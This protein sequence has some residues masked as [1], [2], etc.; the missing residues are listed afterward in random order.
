MY[1]LT[2]DQFR[3]HAQKG[4]LIPVYKEI[5]ADMETP[6]SA[7]HKIACTNSFLLES[8]EGGEN[9]AR[10]SFI[11]HGD[12]VDLDIL[13]QF[14]PVIFSELPRFHGGVVGYFSYD[15]IRQIENIP[16]TNPDELNLPE[17]R[18]IFAK[19]L[20]AFDHVKHKI[21]I[22]SNAFINGSVDDAYKNACS[23][24][25]ILEKKLLEEIKPTTISIN[26]TT[27]PDFKSN[28]TKEEY[29]T[30][31]EKA[32]EYIKAGDIFQVVPSQRFVTDIKETPFDIYRKL[33]IINPSPHMFYLNFGDFQIVGSSP[34]ILVRL[35]KN[36]ATVRPIA[37]TRPRG[38]TVEED[39]TLEKDLLADE[40]ERA[41]HVMLLD[42]GRNDLGRVCEYNT[43]HPTDI[44]IIER[45]SHVMH[46][47]SN[48]EGQLRKDKT[49]VDLFRACFPAGTV[50]GAPK[51]RAMEIIDELETVR[52]GAYAGSVG[53][54]DFAGNMDTCITIR[55]IVIKDGKAYIQAGG[56]IVA[57]SVPETEYQETVNKAK[58]MM[59]ACV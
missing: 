17:T 43:V 54:F 6:V 59:R 18:F 49:A 24:I 11:G 35:E 41:E 50:S 7:Y 23:Q 12:I 29:C 15:Y 48:V 9:V 40:K 33:R 32:K 30:V 16:D 25:D 4:N 19:N 27:E 26:E 8:V 47:V 58:A 3:D 46:L 55:T 5:I 53:Y 51:I 20:L 37:G 21:L 44:M 34:E 39:L 36:T 22:I 1:S 42:L 57:D 2:I 52:R 38:K 14:K 10:Y 13:Q 28:F 45:Y 31:V 56:G